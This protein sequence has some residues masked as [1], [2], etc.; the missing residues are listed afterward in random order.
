MDDRNTGIIEEFRAN[1]GVVGGHFE[2]KR[3]LILHV[4]GRKSG[5]ERLY[6]LIR[7]TDGDSYAVIGS[8]GGAPKDPE[9]VANV[10]AMTEAVIEIGDET[11]KVRPIVLREGTERDRLYEKA[12]EYWPAF[13]ESYEQQTDRKF[14]VIRLDPIS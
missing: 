1:H 2:G 4:I 7:I 10:E 13:R 3:L 11:I 14:P 8:M 9:W 12:V 5:T 6:P